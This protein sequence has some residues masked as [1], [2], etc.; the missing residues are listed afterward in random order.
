PAKLR[1]RQ[2][3]IMRVPVE[4]VLEEGDVMPTR[5]QR[6]A[7][8]TK[9][10]GVTIAPRR[11]DRQSKDDD[12]HFPTLR[13]LG[14]RT[15]EAQNAVDQPSARFIRMLPQGASAHRLTDDTGFGG[16]YI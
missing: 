4:V 8:S 15:R 7:E 10:R 14:F 6:P 9:R 1:M 12:F 13:R 5:V 16:G 3:A 2:I 11:G